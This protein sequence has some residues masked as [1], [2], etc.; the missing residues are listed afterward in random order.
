MA[1]L[2]WSRPW[3]LLAAL[4]VGGQAQAQVDESA[5]KAAFVYNI[6]AFAQWQ[7]PRH[8]QVLAVCTDAGPAMDAALAALDGRAVGSRRIAVQAP[9]AAR[10][11][12]VFV[13]NGRP[14]PGAP[15]GVLVL[16]DGCKLPDQVTAVTLVREESKVRF[17]VDTAP[18][19]R[20]GV[21]FSSQLLRLARRVL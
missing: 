20:A 1:L 13:G 18:A 5:L 7:Q 6:I 8:P 17:E 9:A 11:C 16:C 14:L 3:V 21:T 15:E 19:A 2:T 12:D 4:G 10:P